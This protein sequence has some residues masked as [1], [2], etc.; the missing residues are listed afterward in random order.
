[1]RR[2]DRHIPTVRK[3][4]IATWPAPSHGVIYGRVDAD[5]S[6]TLP[7]LERAAVVAGRPVTMTALVGKAVALALAAAPQLNARIV[8][9][10]V[11]RLASVDVSFFVDVG[12]GRDLSA[13]T[14]SGADTASL[15]DIA[16]R[17]TSEAARARAGVEPRLGSARRLAQRL[18]VPLLRGALWAA[19]LVTAGYGRPLPALGLPADPFGGALVT[20]LGMHGVDIA[21]APLV[22]FARVGTVI[23]VGAVRDRPAVVGGQVVVRPLVTLTATLDHR[24]VDGVEA[25][26]LAALLRRVVE[27]P[28]ATLGPPDGP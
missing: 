3:L 24:L 2:W 19:G 22:P 25:A 5:V 28:Q 16:G 20:S 18:P 13:V 26:R 6:R 21:F 12:S 15:A 14:V 10:R 9:G 8:A 4:A 1:M 17:L 11:R 27:D 23:F 7:Y